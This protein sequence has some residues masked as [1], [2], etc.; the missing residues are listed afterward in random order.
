MRPAPEN[1]NPN[2]GAALEKS[3][4]VRWRI[5]PGSFYA[6]GFA[7]LC[8]AAASLLHWGFGLF[9]LDDQHFTTFYPAVLF[10]A[11]MGG[12]GAGIFAAISGGVVAWWAFMTPHF[13]LLLRDADQLWGALIYLLASVL[14][15]WGADHYR[16]LTKR[17]EDEETFRKLAVD[18]L[19]HRLKNK[20][21][22]IQ[23][24]VSYQL[25]DMPQTRDAIRGRLVALSATDDL[26]MATQGRGARLRDIL[27]TELRPYDASGIKIE[28]PSTFLA[29]KFAM[30]MAMLV[31]ELATNSAK[32][33]ALSVDGGNL[34]V[35]WSLT[36]ARLNLEW[37]ESGG[38]I[39]TAP[40]SYGF[41]MR[42]LSRALDQFEGTADTAFEPTGFVCRLSAKPPEENEA[43]AGSR[44]SPAEDG[45]EIGPQPD[46]PARVVFFDSCRR[47]RAS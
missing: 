1:R 41:G 6:Y 7:M 33:G 27:A 42:L 8:V 44:D 17:L 5:S 38:P 3:A 32:Y 9:M 19:A 28:G 45:T 24:I 22:T 10:T 23:S 2:K 16:R 36:D 25:R 35:C 40:T 13:S 30:T 39:V 34:A 37:R 11:L 47:H 21:A 14:I 4:I 12:A 15:V 20:I 46:E 29:P 43:H 31:H 18:E 26:I